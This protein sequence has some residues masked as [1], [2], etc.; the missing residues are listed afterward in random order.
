MAAQSVAD[1][2]GKRTY[3]IIIGRSGEIV[4]IG[5]S[6]ANQIQWTIIATMPAPVLLGRRTP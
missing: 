4:P 6:P 5:K 1:A 3:R 2:A